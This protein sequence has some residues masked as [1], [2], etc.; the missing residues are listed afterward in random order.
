MTTEEVQRIAELAKLKFSDAEL[1]DFAEEFTRIVDYVGTVAAADLHDVEPMTCCH[2]GAAELRA[3]VVGATL[4]TATAL[5]N[6]PQK[7][8]AFFKVPKVLG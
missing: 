1:A 3:D 7:N 5:S 6:A 4:P 8:E 2:E